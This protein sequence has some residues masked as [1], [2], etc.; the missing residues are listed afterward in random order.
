MEVRD[1][2]VD[3]QVA[4]V[5]VAAAPARLPIM[6]R[7]DQDMARRFTGRRRI[8][9]LM[10]TAPRIIAAGI[11][12]IGADIGPIPGDSARPVGI[13]EAVGAGDGGWASASVLAP[14]LVLAY[15][16]ARRGVGVIT[17]TTIRIG[18]RLSVA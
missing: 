9:S 6:P 5:V 3:S 14:V 10:G 18:F 12:A 15:R 2:A 7:A 16:L 1:A 4:A 8:T 17:L 13:G 11:T